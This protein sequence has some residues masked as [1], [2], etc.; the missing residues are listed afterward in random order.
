MEYAE[1]RSVMTRKP[2]VGDHA[3]ER[4]ADHELASCCRGPVQ[5]RRRAAVDPW[6]ERI[7]QTALFD[8]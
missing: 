6:L 8:S 3:P 1:V 7:Y 4:H 5:I 2:G